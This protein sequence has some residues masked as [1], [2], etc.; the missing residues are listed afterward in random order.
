MS[1]ASLIMHKWMDEFFF[2]DHGWM[3]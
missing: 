2:K 3:S 1:P